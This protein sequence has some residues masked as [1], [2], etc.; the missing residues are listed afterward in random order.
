MKKRLLPWGFSLFFSLLAQSAFAGANQIADHPKA[1]ELPISRIFTV[2]RGFDAN[3]IIEVAVSG[4][5]PDT[6][7]KLGQG[8][9]KFDRFTKKIT[10]SVQ[11]FIRSQQACLQIVTPF[12]EVVPLGVLKAGDYSVEASN[13]TAVKGKLYIKPITTENRDDYLYAPV[14]SVSLDVVT[15]LDGEK[16]EIKL[17]GT[18][19]YMLTGCMR[20][21]E[22]KAYITGN[23]V[24][25]VQ[26]IAEILAD[27]DCKPTDVDAY[28]RFEIKQALN[29]PLHNQGLVHVRTLNGRAV[30]QYF[31]FSKRI[32]N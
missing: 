15:T 30:N 1:V 22:V 17:Q 29:A 11:G 2:E 4:Y 31:D 3:D 16:Q 5:L 13:N 27:Q 20:V 9:A 25:V 18:Y 28:N 14:D 24:L 26:P 23:Q 19:P 10:V 32:I 21:A 7:H 6:C 8:V 12:L